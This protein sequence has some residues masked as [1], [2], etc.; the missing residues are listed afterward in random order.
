[1]KTHCIA[2]LLTVLCAAAHADVDADTARKLA[3]VKALALS[4]ARISPEQVSNALEVKLAEKCAD[5]TEP[6]AGNYHVCIYRPG[7]EDNQPLAFLGYKTVN[8]DA[9]EDTG[10][11][12]MFMAHA[13]RQCLRPEDLIKVF[14]STPV[15]SASPAFPEPTLPYIPVHTYQFVFPGHSDSEMHVRVVQTGD[16]INTVELIRN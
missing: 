9:A 15:A 6:G 16:C 1:M 12:V 4:P 13:D 14:Q 8:R 5:V 2:L 11:V 3:A 10:G 7:E